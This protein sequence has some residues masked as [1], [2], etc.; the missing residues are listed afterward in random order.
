LLNE[1]SAYVSDGEGKNGSGKCEPQATFLSALV[2]IETVRK[3]LIRI[4]D[5]TMAAL[6]SIKSQGVQGLAGNEEAVIWVFIL[7]RYDA[8]SLGISTSEIQTTML[9]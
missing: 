9:S 4:D 1:T 8:V 7:L 3:N 5:N 2:A 6:S